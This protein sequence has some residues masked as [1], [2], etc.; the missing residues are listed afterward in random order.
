MP[1]MHS[2]N[3]GDQDTCIAEF[4]ELVEENRANGLEKLAS[5]FEGNVK[6]GKDHRDAIEK[7]GRFPSRNKALGRE[8]TP[9]EE[10]YMKTGSKWGQ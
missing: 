2:E 4:T 7:F 10:E 3:L 1:F 6:F 5:G 8:S 9:E